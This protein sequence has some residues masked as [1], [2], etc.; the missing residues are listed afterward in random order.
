MKVT[1]LDTLIDN[2]ND[3]Y[4]GRGPTTMS[5]LTLLDKV[6]IALQQYRILLRKEEAK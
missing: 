2:V 5:K 3:W 4:N 6:G 1:D